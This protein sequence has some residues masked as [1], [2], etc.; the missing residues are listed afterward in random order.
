MFR[1]GLGSGSSG[2][3]FEGFDPETGD[4]R[5]VK[6]LVIKKCHTVAMISEEIKANSRASRGC[7]LWKYTP[8]QEKGMAF[9][10]VNWKNSSCTD[11]TLRKRLC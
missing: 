5:A 2:I 10:Q 1:Q 7:T 11:W 9:N 3:V 4:L 6:R 8:F